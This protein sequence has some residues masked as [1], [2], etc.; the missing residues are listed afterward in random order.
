MP[1]AGDPTPKK[2]KR[3]TTKIGEALATLRS[4]NT[5]VTYTMSLSVVISVID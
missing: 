2:D 3:I 5:K 1:Q 4:T